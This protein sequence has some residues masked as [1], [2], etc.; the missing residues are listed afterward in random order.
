AIEEIDSGQR[1]KKD[2]KRI[3]ANDLRL[4]FN[5]VEWGNI[6]DTLRDDLEPH[7]YTLKASSD[8][9]NKRKDHILNELRNS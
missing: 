8:T 9:A 3:N 4:V 5:N 1:V 7:I 2:I 6:I